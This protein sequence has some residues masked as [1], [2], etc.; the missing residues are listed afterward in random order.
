M[1]ANPT[2]FIHFADPRVD[3]FTQ[4]ERVG[5]IAQHARTVGLPEPIDVQADTWNVEV[6]L[7][8][9]ASLAIWA[10]EIGAEIDGTRPTYTAEGELLGCPVQAF[11]VGRAEL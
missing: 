3:L 8:T 9:Y 5:A 6:R 10:S 4:M 2:P 1:T 7:E 11:Y